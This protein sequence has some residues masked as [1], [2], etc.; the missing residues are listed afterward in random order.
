MIKGTKTGVSADANGKFSIIPKSE[1]D[2]ITLVISSVGFV[3]SEVCLSKMDSTL[4]VIVLL[5][6]NST[7]GL[8]VVVSPAERMERKKMGAVSSSIT[9]RS[10]GKASGKTTS[11]NFKI[12]PNPAHSNSILYIG[13][14][15]KESGDFALQ[16][17]N[18]SGH[19]IFTKD[20]YIDKE[21]RLL[22]INIPFVA[23]GN[24]FLKIVNKQTAGSYTGK[25]IIE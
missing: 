13:W 10:Y 25:L 15:Q 22:D 3:P 12:Y 20:I 9:I 5:K 18:Q 2:R 24:Y 4:D 1:W 17:F 19:L 7:L 16:L 6:Q 14:N 21:A 11:N 23:A 8:I